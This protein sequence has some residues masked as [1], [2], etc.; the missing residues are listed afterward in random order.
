MTT[1]ER[2]KKICEE[3]GISISRLE[4]DLNFGKNSMYAW[5]TKTP[6]GEKL[7]KTADY[8]N[9]SVDYL[10][11]RT[12]IKN[13]LHGLEDAQFLDVDGLT[14]ADIAKVESIVEA[15]KEAQRKIDEFEK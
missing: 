3:Q 8:L 6:S 10:L 4:E 9:V 15:L 2:V 1:F 14:P 13:P 7:R 5:K 11:G 12:D